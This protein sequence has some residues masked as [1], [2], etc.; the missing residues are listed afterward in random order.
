MAPIDLSIFPKEREQGLKDIKRYSYFDV[1]MYRTDVW[2]HTQRVLWILEEI[3]PIAQKYVQFDPEKAR[4]NALVHDDEELVTGDVQAIL[5]SLMSEEEKKK[6]SEKEREAIDILVEKYP[7][8]VHGH[9]YKELLKNAKNKDT[10]EAQLVTYCDK[11]DGLME[12]LHEV[13][14]GNTS[15]IRSLVYYAQN[16]PLF[17]YKFPA[18]TPVLQSKES[19]FTFLGNRME[20]LNEPSEKYEALCHPHTE[21]SIKT[22]LDFPFYKRWKELHIER[23]HLD[24]LI[25]QTE[26][27]K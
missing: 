2:M 4:I 22:T 19:V 21:E 27:L 12:S 15:Y 14:A 10:I 20:T 26:F 23:G 9:E 8:I 3:I 17:Q 18:I 13:Y 5:K 7:K 1:M 11:L 24:W 25:T 16:L 6:L